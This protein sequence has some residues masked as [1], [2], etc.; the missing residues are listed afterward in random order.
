MTNRREVLRVL[1][2]SVL[3]AC[4]SSTSAQQAVKAARIGVLWF[5]SSSDAVV[6]RI[7]GV[8]RQRLR[9]LGYV[10]GKTILI[11]DRF[12]E[13]NPQRLKEL[14]RGL[15]DA[16][17]DVIVTPGV[18]ATLAVRQ[19]T[20][21]IPIVMV[22]AG[23]PIGAGL[24]ESLVRPGGNVTG[25]ANVSLG[26][27][28]VELM[29]EVSPRLARLALLVNP[30]NAGARLFVANVT[31]AA[32]TFNIV[33]TVVEVSRPEDFARAYASIREAGVDWLHVVNEPMI[34]SRRAEWVEFAASA[35]LPLSSEVGETARLGGLVSYSPVLTDHYVLAADYVDKILKG[36]KPTD[37]P[38]EEP[39]RYELVLN[40]QTARTLGLTIPR[41]VLLRAQEVIQ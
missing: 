28:D 3:M 7:S 35:R 11:D 25:T 20:D 1:G 23:D 5:A 36:A 40:L 6:R 17:L 8:F 19:A 21:T 29:R 31:E 37:L 16:K 32:R 14:A 41:S 33:V 12:A 39:V 15:A 38:V 30:T 4:A 10:D 9:E 13:G 2:L 27:K 26:G 34:S 22:H 18:A 24:I